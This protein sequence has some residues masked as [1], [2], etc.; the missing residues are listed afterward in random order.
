M[1]NISYDI[2]W[3]HCPCRATDCLRQAKRAAD[4]DADDLHLESFTGGLGSGSPRSGRVRKDC[5]C[6]VNYVM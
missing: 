6:T 5:G 1:P 2:G 3:L 4:K